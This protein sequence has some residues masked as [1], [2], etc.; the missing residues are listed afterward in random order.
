[1]D[2]L[3]QSF[4]DLCTTHSLDS[5]NVGPM[6]YTTGH[7]DFVA[8]VHR[9]MFCGSGAGETIPAALCAAIAELNDKAIALPDEPLPEVAA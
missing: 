6:H 4:L 1:M 2:A 8:F 7:V 9:G 3:S 5:F